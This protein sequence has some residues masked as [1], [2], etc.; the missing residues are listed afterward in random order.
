MVPHY[1]NQ[2]IYVVARH[3]R[4]LNQR[5]RM[6]LSLK[7][8]SLNM[9]LVTKT[10]HQTD[11][12]NIVTGS[13]PNPLGVLRLMRMHRIKK[14]L[15]KQLY[16]PSE[17]ILFVKAA[18]RR[19]E[20]EIRGCVSS[21][22]RVCL[23]TCLPPHDISL[24]GLHLKSRIP[25][26]YWVVDWQDLWSYDEYYFDR[27]PERF[28][29]RILEIEKRVFQMSDLNVTTNTTAK[30]ILESHYKVP[31]ER[32]VA[33][34][35]PFH[36]SDLDPQKM[37]S[38]ISCN[39]MAKKPI[40]IGFLGRIFKP[41]KVPG[42]EIFQVIQDLIKSGLSIK[43]HVFGEDSKSAIKAI[44][45]SGSEAIFLHPLTSHKQSLLNISGCD[46]FLLVMS[47]L[48]NCHA[49]MP[50]KLPHYLMLGR[51]ILAIVPENSAVAKIIRET[52]SGYVIPVSSNW[53]EELKRI[54]VD[55][56]NGRK[57]PIR[58]IQA[59]EKYSWENISKKWLD[60]FR[61]DSIDS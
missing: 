27:V 59:I 41:P 52:G 22:K 14:A 24:I 37:N 11:E 31:A 57:R 54:L 47:D 19:L 17:D 20:K 2:I 46:F 5:V 55:H 15:E 29:S 30:E 6:V 35:H 32:V 12:G 18:K 60:L 13:Y 49:I 4:T 43:L 10:G 50:I 53:A 51:P 1:T 25:E 42:L 39:L 40:D 61:A 3:Q 8:S 28:K 33:I 48:P 16:F 26:L 36:R 56:I 9:V 23:L 34:S 45:E 58:N 21:R 7:E 44:A 38:E